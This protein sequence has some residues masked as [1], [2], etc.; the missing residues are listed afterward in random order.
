MPV[1]GPNRRTFITA[2]GGAATWPMVA[3]GAQEKVWRVGYLSSSSATEVSA[4][5]FEAFRIKLEELGYVEGKI[6]AW[7]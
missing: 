6:S 1:R 5:L 4:A 2:L 7:L 3:R